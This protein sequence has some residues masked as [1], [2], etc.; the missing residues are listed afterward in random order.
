[1]RDVSAGGVVD[2]RTWSPST[3]ADAA[4]NRAPPFGQYGV[5][6]R[7]VVTPFPLA[8][9]RIQESHNALRP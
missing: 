4:V 9:Q 7:F 3:G 1:M 2:S 8:K 5:T 6:H